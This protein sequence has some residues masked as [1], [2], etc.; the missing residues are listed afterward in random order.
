MVYTPTD[1]RVATTGKARLATVDSLTGGITR[2]LLSAERRDCWPG[3]SAT[4][5]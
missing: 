1:V 4:W 2:R 5:L 3:W